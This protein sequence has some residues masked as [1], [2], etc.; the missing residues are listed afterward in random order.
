VL[1]SANPEDA[2]DPASGELWKAGRRVKLQNQPRQVLRVLVS[3]PGELVARE[4][5]RS[6]L[7]PDDTFVDFDAG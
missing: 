7:W 3:R 4:E 1:A 6:E 2:L 5:L